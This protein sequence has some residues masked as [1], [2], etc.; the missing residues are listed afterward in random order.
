MKSQFP[1]QT[2]IIWPM[3]IQL[4]NIQRDELIVN[5]VDQIVED[6]DIEA[7]QQF[8][9]ETLAEGY[10]QCGDVELLDTVLLNVCHDNVDEFEELTEDVLTEN[11]L[12]EYIDDNNQGVWVDINEEPSEATGWQWQ[13][14]DWHKQP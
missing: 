2:F 5:A 6:M 4:T 7:L 10:S 3:N 14:A 11:Q 8:V 13:S 9:K 12:N 1:E